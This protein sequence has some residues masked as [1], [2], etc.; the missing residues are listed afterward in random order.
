[1]TNVVT[2]SFEAWGLVIG[3]LELH[4][5]APKAD[6][7]LRRTA[8][9]N[10]EADDRDGNIVVRRVKSVCQLFVPWAICPLDDAQNIGV[11]DD[12]ARLRLCDG[13]CDFRYARPK[14][15]ISSKTGSLANRPA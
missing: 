4:K 7:K 6:K 3:H 2:R 9:F 13:L 14:R 10:F 5:G 11:E 15:R 12:H 1:M 8:E